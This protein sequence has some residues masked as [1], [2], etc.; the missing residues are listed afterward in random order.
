MLQDFLVSLFADRLFLFGV[1]SAVLSIIAYGPYIYDTARGRTKPER[2]TWLIW[3][4]LSAISCAS[5]IAEGAGPAVW[6]AAV[7]VLGTTV[8]FLQSVSKGAGRYFCKRNSAVL[9]VAGFGLVAWYF[10]ADAVYALSISIGVSMLGGF[11]TLLK[12]YHHPRT[13][14]LPTWVL[15]FVAA[16]LAVASVG[17][18]DPVILAYPAYL[19]LLY[20][21]IVMAVLLGRAMGR[22]ACVDNYVWSSCRSKVRLMPPPVRPPYVRAASHRPDIAA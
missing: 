3:S 17:A 6:F 5:M 15:A 7:Q 1:T 8:I 19:V 9:I 13:E 11:T 22:G 18:F 2:A 12:A 20:G 16:C 21:G 14:T 4:V 10:T